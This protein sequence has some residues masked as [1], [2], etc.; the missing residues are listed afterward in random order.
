MATLSI[1]GTRRVVPVMTTRVRCTVATRYTAII[2]DQLLPDLCICYCLPLVN[3]LWPGDTIWRGISGSTLTQVIGS[4]LTTPNH[5]LNQC[6]LS[7]SD[8]LWHLSESNFTVSSQASI[9]YDEFENYTFKIITTSPIGQW[10]NSLALFQ[11]YSFISWHTNVYTSINS[12][13]PGTFEWN[14]R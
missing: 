2:H 8:V 1:E 14:F 10:V 12:F 11:S 13:A 5:Y 3:S 4:C 6:W 9:L 7:I